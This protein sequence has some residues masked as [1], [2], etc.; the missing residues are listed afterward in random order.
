NG[1]SR[2][3]RTPA[4]E[5]STVRIAT[6]WEATTLTSQPPLR[7]SAKLGL[8]D[9]EHGEHAIG[10]YEPERRGN[11]PQHDCDLRHELVAEHG[12]G[13]H[14]GEEAHTTA[15]ALDPSFVTSCVT[16]R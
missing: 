4:A 8:F 3:A 13:R 10:R 15:M 12:G 1:R 6:D 7:P 11:D 16:I 2:P 14:G 5:I 9:G